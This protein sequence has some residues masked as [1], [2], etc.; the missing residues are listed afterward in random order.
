MADSLLV[1]GRIELLGDQAVSADPR[2]PGAQFMLA[3]G[4]DLGSPQPT[5]DYV[6]SLILDGERPFGRRASN[7]V[8]TL[9]LL[10]KAP[11]RAI[12][13]AAREVLAE[14]IDAQAWSLT[15]TRDP[16]PGGTALPLVLDCF[17]ARPTVPVYNTQW[18]KQACITALT[19]SFEALPYGRSDTQVQVAFAAPVPAWPPPPLPPVILDTYATISSAAHVQSTRCVV[20]P[21]SACWDPDLLGDPGGQVTPMTYG[22]T[23]PA[24]LDLSGMASLQV[25]FGLGSRYYPQLHG[26]GGRIRATFAYTLTDTSGRQLSFS[27]SGLLLPSSADPAVPAFTRVT[28]A[29]PQGH[30]APVFNYSVVASYQLTVTS[31][32]TVPRL[33]WVTAYLDA[34]TAYPVTQTAVP[35]TRGAVH[36]LYGTQ[37]SAP[38]PV[39]L[40]FQ[41]PPAP[42]T[43][44][45]VTAAGAGAYTVPA[46]T[47]WL[48]VEC[49]A[50]G[51]AGA[52]QSAAGFGG[53]GGG[54]E[55]AREDVFPAAPGQ[56]VPYS[57]GAGGTSGASPAPGQATVFGPGPSGP[58]AVIANG[59]Q[60]AAQDS[61]A[62]AAGGTGS[63]NF[64]ARAGGAGRTASGS[65]GGGGGSSGGA[66]AAG[67]TPVGTGAV[68]LTGSGTWIAPAGVTQVTVYAVGGG[69]GGGS[70]SSTVN[71]SGGGGGE[72]AAQTVTVVPGTGYPY[73]VA[74]GGAGGL[75][76][77]GGGHAGS[78]GGNSTFTASAVVTAH[79]GGGGAC[80]TGSGAGG[81]GGTG[82]LTGGHRG[83]NGGNASP[84]AGGGGSSAGTAAGGNGGTGYSAGGVAPA[85]GGNGGNGSGTAAVPGQAGAVPGGGGGGSYIGGQA[86][87]AGAAGTIILTYPGGAPTSA[88]APAIPGGGGGGDGG[89]TANTAGSAGTVPG[90]GG[91]GADSAGSAVAG[92]AGGGGRIIIT[93]YAS[94]PFKS[95]IVHRPGPDAPAALMPLVP[96]GGG[97]GIPDGATEYPVPQAAPAPP[98]NANT[99]FAATTAP[100]TAV[101]NATLTRST[102]WLTAGS[103]LF[104]GDGVTAHPN[105][106]SENTIPV[107]AGVP[108]TASAL[109]YSPQGWAT[110][111]I[112]ISWYQANGAFI[113]STSATFSIP[114]GVTAGTAVTVTGTPPPLA[115][116]CHMALQMTNTPASTVLMYAASAKVINPAAGVSARFDGT[117][118]VVLIASSW[119]SPTV[120]RTITVTVRQYEA[121]GGTA[122]SVST[123]PVTVS[124]G[125][126]SVIG[127]GNQVNNGILCAG[128]LTL[129]VK[130]VA[131][132]NTAGYYTVSVTDTN[133]SDRFYDVL[134]L[135]VAGQSV[136]L[137]EASGSGYVQFYLDEPVPSV[138]LGLHLGS[139]SGRP[140]AISVMDACQAISGGPLTIPPND[141][142]LLTYS[143]DAS[144]PAI[145]L[146]YYSRW[147]YD[148][149]E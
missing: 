17:R 12:L 43:K 94:P 60:S 125:V 111:A 72:S 105:M 36:A 63:G 3:P 6:A 104:S 120:A 124:P 87:G 71:G 93:P 52:S 49:V 86:G 100:W 121:P 29:I 88:G 31:R 75:G 67:S 140:Q 59:G 50:G 48:K 47:A 8:L 114:A 28:A 55:Y 110:T 132:D 102:A 117:Y 24:P 84:Y 141:C 73:A 126:A 128:V 139:Q 82:A 65:V 79:G 108:Y 112:G 34:L 89:G 1:G 70:G 118:T 130:A 80:Y 33:R 40:Q 64:V 51:G 41:Q 115:A 26:H 131:G 4:F 10:I 119:N 62:G 56:S 99:T 122:Y 101:N 123:V 58:L 53:G 46:G 66:G 14:V 37:G 113:S 39:S 116:T 23:F 103:A 18:E 77:G 16:G 78:A 134:L 76:S 107:T 57:V 146:S 25:W 148:R 35:V 45:T 90:G 92:G 109:L 145:G 85:G 143:A 83:G 97:T 13:A 144:A 30:T 149:T 69:G 54:G 91:G 68:T 11:T 27:R 106:T 81:A 133:T 38:A 61:A 21:F 2:C 15:W 5:A 129:P 98:L 136:I 137:N 20:G 42:G 9:P 142:Q 74:A 44:T 19:V 96:A 135:D 32:D 147:F 22:A 95:L 7:R 138:D 127:P